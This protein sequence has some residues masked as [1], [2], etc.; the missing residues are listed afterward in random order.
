MHIRPITIDEIPAWRRTMLD[1]FGIDHDVDPI[2][3]ERLQALVDLSRAFGAFEGTAIVGT[4]AAFDFE[5]T[6]PGGSVPM[7]GL[8]MVAVH[9][10]RRRRGVLRALMAAH[11]E[12]ARAHGDP[13]SGLF[14]SEATIYGRFGYG[15]AVESDSLTFTT[16]G[17]RIAENLIRDEVDR[18]EDPAEVVPDVYARALRPGML[19]RNPTWWD[20]RRFRERPD[21]RSGAT[22]RRYV[23][24]RRDGVATGYICYRQ[25]FVMEAGAFAGA[26]E[27]DE[28]VAVDARAEASLWHYVAHVDLY[29]TVKWWN[30]P[31]DTL[32]PW[33]LNDRRKLQSRR[34]DTLWL[35]IDDVARC[36]TA[37]TYATD[38][39][40]RIK[41]DD[42]T[43]LLSVVGGRGKV[44]AS[45][46]A[47]DIR[48]DRA[49]LGSIYLG[50]VQPSTLARAGQVDGSPAALAK[51][52]R[53]FASPIAPWCP[54]VF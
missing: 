54:E 19:A 30:A 45:S 38:E 15:V 31:R 35:R 4:A 39:L 11:L 47:P 3:V 22:P 29:P 50:G 44:I 32:A 34:S 36:L 52:D 20:Y 1:T 10:T 25:R 13:L 6:V 5:L 26:F 43:H 23:V 24:C 27:I 48:V 46:E 37:R 41:V 9:P 12:A 7:S 18:L 40:L 28:L 51:A 42:D 21:L 49:A 8:T 14:A 33:L 16:S 17:A 2:G 53:M